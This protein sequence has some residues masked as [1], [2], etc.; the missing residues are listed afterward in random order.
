MNRKV[1]LITGASSGFGLHASL[2]FAERGHEVVA[3]MRNPETKG[4]LLDQAA[5]L[6]V[7][8]R[9]HILRLDVTRTEDIRSV[10]REIGERFGRLDVLVNNAGY[11]VGGMAE[12]VPLSDWR[13]LL[14]TNFFGVIAMTQAALPIM[15]SQRR[16]TILNVGSISG[17]IGIPGYAP[18]CSSKFAVEGFSES[19]RHEVRGFGV[20]VVLVEPGSYKTPIWNKGFDRIRAAPSSP[21]RDL[22]DSVLG[23]SRRTAEAAP[24]PDRLA[25]KIVALAEKKSPSLRYAYGKG[26][27][28]SLLGKAILPWKWFERVLAA[29]LRA[30]MNKR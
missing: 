29:A 1:V 23:Y 4:E 12:E 7:A 20:D 18:Y 10:M 11:A 2:R 30:G 8:S 19:L 17:K 22:L 5:L 6:G 24:D 15:R 21:Y 26:A 25:R 14:E 28:L 13:A 16:G 27:K 9:I 3:T